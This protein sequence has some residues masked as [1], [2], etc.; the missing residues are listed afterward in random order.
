MND[1]DVMDFGIDHIWGRD[2]EV[3][4]IELKG[5][6]PFPY[7]EA[8]KSPD[9]HFTRYAGALLIRTQCRRAWLDTRR[10]YLSRWIMDDYGYLVHSPQLRGLS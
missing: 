9:G 3:P 10:H 1:D 6:P 5:E 4:I 2:V 8:W 7:F